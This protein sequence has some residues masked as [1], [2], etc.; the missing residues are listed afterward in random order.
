MKRMNVTY[1]EFYL[2]LPLKWANSQTSKQVGPGNED[3]IDAKL[4][5]ILLKEIES[6][7][8][9]HRYIYCRNQILKIRLEET[10]STRFK[11]RNVKKKPTEMFV[12]LTCFSCGE[13]CN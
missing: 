12:C 7:W 9:D 5:T 3:K 8:K 11:F 1:I 2:I 4:G 13:K 6:R 10:T